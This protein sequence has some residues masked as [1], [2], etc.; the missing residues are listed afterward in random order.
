MDNNFQSA[1]YRQN[2]PRRSVRGS[3]V[4]LRPAWTRPLSGAATTR[5]T[6]SRCRA[7]SS[8]M[9]F[10]GNQYWKFDIE[11]TP[12]VRLDIYPKVDTA[13]SPWQLT[14]HLHFR[15]LFHL[16]HPMSSVCRVSGSGGGSRATWTPPSS[17]RMAGPT[18]SR[19]ASTGGSMTSRP[20]WSSP[21]FQAVRRGLRGAA[22]P[23][24][25]P[26]L[27]LQLLRPK[28]TGCRSNQRS[29]RKYQHLY[30]SYTGCCMQG[31]SQFKQYTGARWRL[32]RSIQ[33]GLR[34]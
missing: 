26:G 19:A 5:S 30:G 15:C 22:L 8:L 21:P 6:S 20:P 4:S 12:N 16:H 34:L 33:G 29:G 9:V 28:P 14:H 27:A 11:K 32:L 2:T 18:S 3:P 31:K 17:G 7:T 13:L 24:Q 23:P 1:F 25:R 10:Q